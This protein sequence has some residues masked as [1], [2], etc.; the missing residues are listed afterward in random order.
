MTSP[1]PPPPPGFWVTGAPTITGAP[2]R[3]Q[4]LWGEEPQRNERAFPPGGEAR[5]V[6]LAATRARH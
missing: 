2:T 1:L 3:P 4:V 5:D 6:E